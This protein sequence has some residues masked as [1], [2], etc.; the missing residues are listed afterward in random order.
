M[1]TAIRTEVRPGDLGAICEQHAR[2]YAAEVHFDQSFEADCLESL[3]RRAR[4][5]WPAAP[6]FSA[7]LDRDGT[8]VGSAML[9]DE[10]NGRGELRFLLVEPELRCQGLGR[11][12]VAAVIAHARDSGFGRITLESCS[13]LVASAAL[14]R[15]QG[16]RIVS[17]Q[18]GPRWGRAEL[19][20]EFW[21]LAL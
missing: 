21:E 11:Q 6:E 8:L 14:F 2:L 19:I 20:T 12:L 17:T 1:A 15:Q 10:G 5:S 7:I 16:F 13:D 9:T 18:T 4:G 3:A